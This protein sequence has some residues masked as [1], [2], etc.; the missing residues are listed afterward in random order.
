MR[1]KAPSVGQAAPNSLPALFGQA[2]REPRLAPSVPETVPSNSEKKIEVVVFTRTPRIEIDGMIFIKGAKSVALL[3]A[4]ADQHLEAAGQ[5]LE[6]FDYPCILAAKLAKK[7]HV[8]EEALRR[9]I[10]RMRSDLKGRFQSAGIP[11]AESLEFI[12]NIPW[13]GY[14]LASDRVTVRRRD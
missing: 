10:S 2:Q 6:L 9:Q 12:E 4:L 13:N 3:A 11:N 1:T 8:T 14:R 5:G 7:L